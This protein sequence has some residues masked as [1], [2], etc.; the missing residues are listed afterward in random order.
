MIGTTHRRTGAKTR[1]SL[2]LCV[3]A[4]MRLCVAPLVAQADVMKMVISPVA[5]SVHVISGFANGNI[6]VVEGGM[7]LLLV[8]AQSGKRVALADSALRTVT[9]KPVR[10]VVFTHYHEDHTQGMSYWKAKGAFAIAH[11]SV[12]I[13]MRKDTTITDRDWHRTPA[14]AEA[15]PT[16]EFR[17]SMMLDVSGSRI[18]VHH[19][20]PAHTNG[21]AVVI[22]PWANVIHTGDLVEPGAPPFIDFW[23]GGSLQGMIGAAEW[24]LRRANDSTKI[25]PGHGPVI[26]KATVAVHRTMLIALRDRVGAAVREG[27]T[28]EQVLALQPAKEWE[29]LLGGPRG[30]TIFVKQVYYGLKREA[31]AP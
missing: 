20:P 17:D 19:V 11:Q 22:I 3:C 6:L 27:K 26:D 2:F 18:W 24:I 23:V 16:L 12:A 13:E 21:D 28:E 31:K 30:A 5:P 1:A 15:M 10:Q 4:S 9:L 8:D 14:A 25:V 7:D 29:T